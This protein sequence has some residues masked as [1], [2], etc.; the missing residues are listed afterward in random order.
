MYAMPQQD[1]KVKTKHAQTKPPLNRPT[2]DRDTPNEMKTMGEKQKYK[3]N[4]TLKW[5]NRIHYKT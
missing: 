2:V 1:Q 4:N 3:R 5:I